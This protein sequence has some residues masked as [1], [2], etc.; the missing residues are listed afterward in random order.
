MLTEKQEVPFDESKV[1]AT[2]EDWE[3]FH[4]QTELI[5]EKLRRGPA[6]NVELAELSLKYT[7]RISD[8]R[9]RGYKIKCKRLGG[10]ITRYELDL[11]PLFTRT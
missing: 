3:R 2:K 6:T 4:T 8:A 1:E 10:G 9:K 7:S 11:G 5:I